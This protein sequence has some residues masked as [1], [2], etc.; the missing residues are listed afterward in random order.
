MHAAGRDE[1]ALAAI[2]TALALGT[3]NASFYFHS[4]MIKLAL[5]DTAGA[6]ADLTEAMAINPY[7]DPLDSVI[8]TKT[9]ETL[10]SDG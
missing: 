6:R 1:E 3:R 7:F 10:K 5:G 2:E 9:L 8:A 4:G